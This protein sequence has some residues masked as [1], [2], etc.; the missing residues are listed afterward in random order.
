LLGLLSEDRY[1]ELLQWLL[2]DGELTQSQLAERTGLA[3]PLLS[4]R[5]VELENFGLIG[6]IPSE[7]T[8]VSLHPAKTS[9]LLRL[10]AELA[11]D[12]LSRQA[13]EAV[14]RSRQLRDLGQ[15]SMGPEESEPW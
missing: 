10:A 1:A 4:R 6:R 5:L 9:D 14:E 7:R 8:Y 11:S 15:Q 2:R 3:P 12:V 13:A